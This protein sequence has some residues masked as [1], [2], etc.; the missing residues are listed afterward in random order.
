MSAVVKPKLRNFARTEWTRCL[1]GSLAV[2]SLFAIWF[3]INVVE[4]RKKHYAS[5]YENYDDDKEYEAMRKAGVFKG[6]EW[7]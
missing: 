4:A 2:G 7:P 6:F 3:K 1:F 5:F